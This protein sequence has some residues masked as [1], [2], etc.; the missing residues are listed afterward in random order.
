MASLVVLVLV[1]TLAHSWWNVRA[2]TCV[3]ECECECV[4]QLVMA[5]FIVLMCATDFQRSQMD[6]LSFQQTPASPA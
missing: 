6:A 3:C 4:R 1:Y 2:A 5:P